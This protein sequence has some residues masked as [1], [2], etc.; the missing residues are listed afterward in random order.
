MMMSKKEFPMRFRNKINDAMANAMKYQSA[1]LHLSGADASLLLPV[2]FLK[3]GLSNAV[4]VKAVRSSMPLLSLVF[5]SIEKALSSAIFSGLLATPFFLLSLC[6]SLFS[7]IVMFSIQKCAGNKISAVG[8]SVAG[9]A[10]SAVCQIALCS[11][12]LGRG[13]FSLL[14]IMLLFSLFSGIITAVVSEKI[15]VKDE[16]ERTRLPFSKRT[17]I[18]A[19]CAVLFCVVSMRVENIFVLA[20]LFLLCAIA[21]VLFKVKTKVLPFFSIAIFCFLSA[22]FSPEGQVLFTLFSLK[23]T[24]ISLLVALRKTLSLF[25][26][27]LFSRLVIVLS[28]N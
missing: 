15:C 20:S 25:A 22:I 12:Y 17:A 4:V 1:L 3:V 13:A 18:C 9:S 2:P 11:L 10:S 27:V 24:S 26:C 5:L 23:I 21:S 6:Q 8:I 28:K 19:L 14:P 7:A 16:G